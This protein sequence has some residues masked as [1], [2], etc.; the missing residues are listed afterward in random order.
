[1]ALAAGIRFTSAGNS[2]G[3][4]CGVEQGGEIHGIGIR[5]TGFLAADGANT[6]ALLDGMR[7]VLDDAILEGPVFTPAVLE[8]EIAEVDAGTHQLA[9]GAVNAVQIEVL[10]GKKL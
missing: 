6:H 7:T 9:H 5:E 8:I 3:G 4:L 10:R 2:T 1:M